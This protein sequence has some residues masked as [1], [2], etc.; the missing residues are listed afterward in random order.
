MNRWY[1]TNI[2]ATMLCCRLF[3]F[4]M[5]DLILF[6]VAPHLSNSLA[7]W[8]LKFLIRYWIICL[9]YIGLY[10]SVILDFMSS[11]LGRISIQNILPNINV[12]LTRQPFTYN[13]FLVFTHCFSDQLLQKVSRST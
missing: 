11:E 1:H 2:S 5:L 13:I 9:D 7:F 3:L 6:R 10:V 12:Q 8:A 4:L